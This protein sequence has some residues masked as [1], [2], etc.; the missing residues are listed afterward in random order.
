MSYSNKV[1]TNLLLSVHSDDS[2]TAT[3]VPATRSTSS[4]QFSDNQLAPGTAEAGKECEEA[5]VTSQVI[6]YRTWRQRRMWWRHMCLRR[7]RDVLCIIENRRGCWWSA[8]TWNREALDDWGKKSVG[9]SGSD[10]DVR[11]YANVMMRWRWCQKCLG[12]AKSNPSSFDDLR[13]CFN[14]WYGLREG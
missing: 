11:G 13:W 14:R 8:W 5:K 10:C 3:R 2:P 9:F 1:F 4:H 12:E 6:V 7:E